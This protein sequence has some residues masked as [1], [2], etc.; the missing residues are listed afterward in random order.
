[1]EK[2]KQGF[3]ELAG[4]IRS[5][6]GVGPK[7]ALLLEKKG[8]RSIEDLLYFLPMRYEDR[9]DLRPMAA[10]EEGQKVLVMGRVVSAGLRFYPR[11]RKRVYEAVVTDGT[12][13]LF[14]KW[15]KWTTQY[16]R[17][18]CKPGNLLLLAGLAKRFGGRMEIVHPVL[19]VLDDEADVDRYATVIPVYPEIEGLKQGILRNLVKTALADYGAQVVSVIP[20]EVEESLGLVSLRMAFEGIHSQ[21]AFPEDRGVGS[22]KEREEELKEKTARDRER[23][24]FE[25]YFLFQAALHLKRSKI[26]KEKG[27]SCYTGGPYCRLF[28]ERLGFPLTK[29]QERVIGEIENDMSSREPMNRLLQG[30]VGS[31]KTVCAVVAA[32]IALD[33][34]FQVAVMAPTEIL[35]EQHYLTFR[36]FFETIGVEVVLLRGGLGGSRKGV[37]SQ[38][39]KGE[40]SLVIGTHALIQ[41]DVQFHKLG[42]LII[43][44]QHRFGVIQRSLLRQK[45]SVPWQRTT[46]GT[47]CPTPDAQGPTQNAEG[48]YAPHSL[49]M[50]ATP[51]PRTLSMVI[52]GDLDVS[53]IDEMPAGR[54]PV[55]T[56]VW[57][58]GE[59]EGVYRAVE[60]EVAKGRQVY[61]VYPLVEESE[62]RDLLNAKNMAA[63]FQ[64]RVFPR[65]TVGL[66]YGRMEVTEKERVMRDFKAGRVDILV[67]TT[68]IEVGIDVP[69]ATMIVIEHAEM[70]GL[71]QLHQLRGRVGRGSL[72]SRCLLVAATRRTDLATKRLR[73]MEETGDGFRIAEEDLKIRGPG[74]MLGVRQSGLP[75][76]RVGDIMRDGDIMSRARKAAGEVVGAIAGDSLNRLQTMTG[77]RW[78]GKT[79]FSEIA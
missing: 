4:P 69:N 46:P 17:T 25:E 40:I 78:K 7:T 43:D 35:A 2:W 54:Q 9:R 76:F 48:F 34:G 45:G 27:L 39:K 8:I 24:I 38:I 31:G 16:M 14:L 36:G 77:R 30:D 65:R 3:T 62:K 75:D 13:N 56:K 28:R 26:K 32:C 21:E 57:L 12:E 10:V 73:I 41:E 47:Q 59:K 19:S 15:F 53:I 18:V 6:R 51:I 22:G 66:L 70:F 33:S 23:L 58:D 71:S 79:G 1:M 52:Y 37:L 44:E 72:A 20:R 68:V 67:C 29:A 5:V 55:F 50:T 63:H 11:T 49:V 60:K 74:E 42:L 61:I 64:D